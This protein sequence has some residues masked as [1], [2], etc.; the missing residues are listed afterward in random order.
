MI[1]ICEKLKGVDFDVD[2][3]RYYLLENVIPKYTPVMQGPAFGGWSI[4]SRTGTYVDGWQQGHT[5]WKT[6]DGKLVFD[7]ELAKEIGVVADHEHKNPTEIC[8]GYLGEV[9]ERLTDLKFFPRRARI[10]VL[11]PGGRTDW[12][13]DAKPDVYAVR[14]HIPIITNPHCEFLTEDEGSVHM[15]ADGSAYLVRVNRL[16]QAVNLG[17]ADRYHLITQAWDVGHRSDHYRYSPTPDDIKRMRG[18]SL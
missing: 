14:L 8:S 5:C 18:Q 4:L 7:R 1:L 6:V 3:L 9:M 11:R 12:H 17:D 13:R 16:H 2:R 10:S 15:P